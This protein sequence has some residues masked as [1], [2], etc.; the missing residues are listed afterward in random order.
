MDRQTYRDGQ[1]DIGMDRQTYV[2][3]N[4]DEIE[5]IVCN[6]SLAKSSATGQI[7]IE[8]DIEMDRQTQGWMDIDRQTCMYIKQYKFVI[9]KSLVAKI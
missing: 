8:M 7:D 2:N 1:I 3:T 5:Y 9:I 6:N 4:T